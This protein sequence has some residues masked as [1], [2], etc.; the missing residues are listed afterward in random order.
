VKG[1]NRLTYR[2][3]R[4]LDLF[5]ARHHTARFDLMLLLRTPLL[6]LRARDAG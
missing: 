6:V 2:Q 4:R 5:Y 3:R 1:R